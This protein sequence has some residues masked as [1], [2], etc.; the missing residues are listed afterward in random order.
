MNTNLLQVNLVSA[1]VKSD[2]MKCKCFQ[3]FIFVS[4][5]QNQNCE[6]GLTATFWRQTWVVLKNSN[7]NDAIKLLFV[8]YLCLYA[9]KVRLLDSSLSFVSLSWSRITN[10]LA[11]NWQNFAQ[12]RL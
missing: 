7:L 3:N 2:F 4:G 12:V 11:S 6:C 1:C 8:F 5:Y 10:K 9:L